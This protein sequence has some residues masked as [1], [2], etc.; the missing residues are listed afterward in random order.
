VSALATDTVSASTEAAAISDEHLSVIVSLLR[1]RVSLAMMHAINLQEQKFY[2]YLPGLRCTSH[3][4][5]HEEYCEHFAA[6]RRLSGRSAVRIMKVR[7]LGSAVG[8][9][10]AP[11][12]VSSYVIDDTIAIDAGAIGLNGTP[13]HQS[14]IRHVF[15]THCHLDHIATLPVFLENSYEPAR[16]PVVIYGHPAALADLQKHVFNDVIWP[17]FVRLTTE[18]TPLIRLCPIEP[19]I[20]VLVNGLSVIPSPVDH[21]VPAYGYIVTNSLSTV[22]FG[23]DSGP[24]ERIWQLAALASAPRSV[25]LETCFPDA[26]HRLADVSRHMTPR[27]V[28]AEVAKMPEMN[29]IIVVHIKARFREA[30]VRELLELRISNLVVGA[31]DSDYLL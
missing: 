27:L 30:V 13:R 14:A 22:I 16:G 12:Y 2:R 10:P 8:V 23:G 7:I 1:F 28:A 15:L 11:Q 6:W 25:F 24:T 4:S 26:M 20:P 5:N 3:M 9:T 18:S 29:A 19:E 17:D 31:P 21:I